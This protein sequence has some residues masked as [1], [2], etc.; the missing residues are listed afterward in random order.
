MVDNKRR[1]DLG[2]SATDPA[3]SYTSSTF[4]E[5]SIN[6]QDL[7]G[8]NQITGASTS[9]IDLPVFNPGAL[10][11][12]T[13]P[14]EG[15]FAYADTPEATIL[16]Q[17]KQWAEQEWSY[18][19]NS[20]DERLGKIEETKTRIALANLI[21]RKLDLLNDHE[22]F[23]KFN[24]INA[25]SAAIQQQQSN[26][27]SPQNIP[28][29]NLT[30][31]N[32]ADIITLAG[33]PVS[34]YYTENI[35]IT[36]PGEETTIPG[37]LQI[38]NKEETVRLA[39]KIQVVNVQTRL[40]IRNTP[41]GKII[42][43]LAPNTIVDTATFPLS[44]KD[45][46]RYGNQIQNIV[47]D[48]PEGIP[49][50]RRQE[51][52]TAEWW[53][54][55]L[56]KL[57]D[58]QVRL[59]G[60]AN[61]VQDLINKA[62][63]V[64]DGTPIGFVSRFGPGLGQKTTVLSQPTGTIQDK[65]FNFETQELS[66]STTSAGSSTTTN[67][68]NIFNGVIELSNVTNITTTNTNKTSPDQATITLENPDNLL[69]ISEDDIEIALGT[70]TLGSEFTTTED[71]RDLESGDKITTTDP[72][73]G[74]TTELFFHNGK[75][76]TQR[77]FNLVVRQDLS[78]VANFTQ[79]GAVFDIKKELQA[80]D[81]DIRALE[82]YKNTGLVTPELYK[83]NSRLYPIEGVNYP[84]IVGLPD[85]SKKLQIEFG[86]IDGAEFIDFGGAVKTDPAFV[87]NREKVQ[88]RVDLL[89]NRKTG[90]LREIDRQ[91]T[92]NNVKISPIEDNDRSKDYR[93][94]QLRK[95]FQNRTI[96]E[97]YDRVHIWMSSP[98]RTTSRLSDGTVVSE[99]SNRD[100]NEQI[101]FQRIRDIISL[102]KQLDNTIL[103]IAS[104][105]EVNVAQQ[106]PDQKTT[107]INEELFQNQSS[108]TWQGT[109]DQIIKAFS[110]SGDLDPTI[111]TLIKTIDGRIEDLKKFF[112]GAPRNPGGGILSSDKN[113][114]QEFFAENPNNI[115]GQGL[116]PRLLFSSDSQAGLSE[117]QQQV[118]QGVITGIQR[119]YQDG[120]FVITLT[121]E[122]NLNFLNRSRYIELPSLD[123]PSITARRFMDDPIW[124]PERDQRL[125]DQVQNDQ[126]LDNLAGRWKT[127]IFT[128]SAKLFTG[129]KDEKDAGE[130]Q[131]QDAESNP[132]FLTEANLRKITRPFNQAFNEPF[133]GADP[134]SILSVIITGQPLDPNL[135]KEN[136]KFT[137]TI[138][139]KALDE[140]NNV[141]DDEK[142][143][144][145]P[146]QA[147]R[148]QIEEQE[149]KYG[150]FDPFIDLSGSTVTEEERNEINLQSAI[151][152][153]TTIVNF[154]QTYVAGREG[155]FSSV[156]ALIKSQKNQQ[157]GNGLYKT[158]N[159]DNVNTILEFTV[160]KMPTQI[161]QIKIIP[162]ALGDS[163]LDFLVRS[164]I[165]GVKTTQLNNLFGNLST[166]A[167]D[168]ARFK[169][170]DSEVSSE[171][172]QKFISSGGSLYR[173]DSVDSGVYNDLT[174]VANARATRGTVFSI[175][176]NEEGN[177]DT[178]EAQPTANVNP[179]QSA[180]T[181]AEKRHIAALRGVILSE[182]GN[183][184]I[185]GNPI[186]A[187]KASIIYNQKPNFFI[188][189]NEYFRSPNLIDYIERIRPNPNQFQ[190]DSWKTVLQRASHAAQMIDW[191]L[192]ADSQGHI[193]FKQPTYNRTLLRHILDLNKIDSFL[194]SPFLNLFKDNNLTEALTAIIL[195]KFQTLALETKQ[196]AI[197]QIQNLLDEANSLPIEQ[198][199]ISIPAIFG[200]TAP[201]T[202]LGYML[203]EQILTQKELRQI[204]ALISL[205][206]NSKTADVKSSQVPQPFNQANDPI[207]QAKQTFNQIKNAILEASKNLA[208][209]QVELDN[210]TGVLGETAKGFQTLFADQVFV[211]QKQANQ[212]YGKQIQASTSQEIIDQ[213][214]DFFTTSNQQAEQDLAI[215]TTE[216]IRTA[217][218]IV[219]FC[220]EFNNQLEGLLATQEGKISSVFQDLTDQKFIHIITN[221]III[222][223]SYSENPPEYTRLDLFSTIPFIGDGSGNFPSQIQQEFM[224]WAGSVDFDLWRI[225]GQ[226]KSERMQVPFLRTADQAVLYA[227]QLMARQYSKILK[228]QITVRGDSK[229]QVG[230]TVFIE[231]ENIYYY[232]V[233]VSHNF[234]YGSSYTTS[235]TL[236]YGRRPGTYIAYPFDV[237]GERLI[238]GINGIYQTDGTN[239]GDF[240]NDFDQADQETTQ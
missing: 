175:L 232:V 67:V 41:S 198:D 210:I 164:A 205:P 212:Q 204:R 64:V 166:A 30:G 177:D 133:R 146:F 6:L 100:G 240:L 127:G 185:S 96:F 239:L 186:Q 119:T 131:S 143:R 220:T 75:F 178:T 168:L 217:A 37:K 184:V 140:D 234:G 148:R 102:I 33:T 203:D 14:G 27:L 231:D 31:K 206:L 83:A 128:A 223:E 126:N 230:D 97:V 122:D 224:Q 18:V 16:I 109:K 115:A 130:Q 99:S 63:V 117:Q 13:M 69:Y 49:E 22:L 213:F 52:P 3:A 159:K 202:I 124:R 237:L 142:I 209:D 65:I 191:E 95:Y 120:K 40:R 38:K 26:E 98:S 163:R 85:I 179:P 61:N 154:A 125:I 59:S 5:G 132:D 2:I 157:D 25:A 46:L 36:V 111:N 215:K 187:T 192:Y 194:K 45:A 219:Q 182:D 91:L 15:G 89:K 156:V 93:R 21:T 218:A 101:F 174:D 113:S 172:I 225:Y 158:I 221:S 70:R 11:A 236:E 24:E 195:R 188:L 147:V 211:E 134:A 28:L 181:I 1:D 78:A 193:R 228:G 152:L 29:S 103:Q 8:S 121:C 23:T 200:V 81:N 112:K 160:E 80:I 35:T 173:L 73:T 207:K 88:K 170:F 238:S 58:A 216:A 189:S 72:Q 110:G 68:Q 136:T 105:L 118:F 201:L 66:P 135:W 162:G 208:L 43:A 56:T 32:L 12:R 116:D 54:I 149:K 4:N 222:S 71:G 74:R 87:R 144:I 169:A 129:G 47:E 7:I 84:T 53:A 48:V 153:A 199:Q 20:S 62:T 165:N 107:Q 150:D 151:N 171:T 60:I 123:F 108:E 92:S 77:A 10:G 42:G 19:T 139:A 51:F 106:F 167:K 180:L 114:L 57:T 145:S 9:A 138:K 155:Q 226:V 34:K 44:K 161:Q 50:E 214:Q 190:L 90:L 137:G 176:F 196:K 233:A 235:L 94:S 39:Q 82:N 197:G 104:Q 79:T 17:K 55:D 141:K 86:F 229:Y 183:K 227:H 76:Y